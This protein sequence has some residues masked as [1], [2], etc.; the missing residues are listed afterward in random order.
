MYTVFS[1][2]PSQPAELAAIACLKEQYRK[3]LLKNF[4][5]LMPCD[6]P[7]R[8]LGAIL[9][10]TAVCIINYRHL[11]ANT[12][13]PKY[14]SANLAENLDALI[15]EINQ[16][17]EPS[18]QADY[19]ADDWFLVGETSG[20]KLLEAILAEAQVMQACKISSTASQKCRVLD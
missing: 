6:C 10:Y 17:L 19:K 20:Q 5:T 3:L 16:I 7:Y 2:K 14:T 12:E 8:E 1:L 13:N 15:T 18:N 9:E 4:E 11:A